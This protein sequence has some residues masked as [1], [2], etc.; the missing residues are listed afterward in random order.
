[1]QPAATRHVPLGPL[2][3]ANEETNAS[4][5][6]DRVTRLMLNAECDMVIIDRMMRRLLQGVTYQDKPTGNDAFSR[7]IG[8]DLEWDV[9][10]KE[11]RLQQAK[12]WK[13]TMKRRH[14]KKLESEI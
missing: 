9:I 4:V 5:A 14:H 13:A 8:Y 7:H 2:R 6:T 11:R 3:R 10:L 12:L 1:M